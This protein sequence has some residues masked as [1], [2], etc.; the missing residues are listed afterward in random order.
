MAPFNPLLSQPVKFL[1]PEQSKIL[2][3]H[4][5][6]DLEWL[7][8]SYEA[9][10]RRFSIPRLQAWVADPGIRYRYS[11]NFLP[12]QVWTPPLLTLRETLELHCQA[13]FNSVLITLY[14]NGEDSVGWHADDERE[15]GESPTIASLSLGAQRTFCYRHKTLAKADQLL[16]GDGDLIVMFPE[17]QQQWLHSVPPELPVSEPRINLTFRNV[18]IPD[19]SE[20]S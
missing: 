9:F 18:V 20:V 7:Q 16:L 10:G 14:R 6:S 13:S 8:D 15:L 19:C 11:D 17:F 12:S 1:A 5:I 3:Q 4:L 2:Y